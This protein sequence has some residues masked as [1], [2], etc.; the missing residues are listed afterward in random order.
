MILSIGLQYT[1]TTVT[2]CYDV[3]QAL[4]AVTY[5]VVLCRMTYK[6]YEQEQEPEQEGKGL[7]EFEVKPE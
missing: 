2:T 6:K 7:Q 4:A 3:H 5:R 1:D